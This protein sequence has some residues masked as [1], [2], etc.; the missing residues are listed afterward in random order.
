MSVSDPTLRTGA[1]FGYVIRPTG[2]LSHRG[3]SVAVVRVRLIA[4]ARADPGTR[5]SVTE[6]E[7]DDGP[8]RTRFTDDERPHRRD[9]SVHRRS[10]GRRAARRA[11]PAPGGSR[12]HHRPAAGHSEPATAP[13]AAAARQPARA[14]ARPAR[15][16]RRLYA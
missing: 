9:S 10:Q 13:R 8:L 14:G 1:G 12:Q 11:A 2:G 15:K 6:T 7:A 4:V 16:H 3:L 5:K